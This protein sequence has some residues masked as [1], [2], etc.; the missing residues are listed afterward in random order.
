MSENAVTSAHNDR[1]LVCGYCGLR[2][3]RW[4]SGWKH[5]GNSFAPSCGVRPTPDRIMTKAA[6]QRETGRAEV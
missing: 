1:D 5:A 2:V 3:L 4:S 6:Y